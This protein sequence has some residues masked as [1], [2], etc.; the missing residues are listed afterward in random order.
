MCSEKNTMRRRGRKGFTFIEIM[1]V[2]VI[3]GLLAGAVTLKVMGNV[4]SA[5]VSR[6]RSDIATIKSAIESYYLINS[7]F[8]TNDEGLENLDISSR[9]D[10]WGFVYEYNCPGQDNRSFEVVTYG[11]DGRPGGDGPNADIYSWQLG[12]QVAG[13]NR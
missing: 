8:P 10:P 4:D 6:A 5:K 12:D 7:R 11:A 2:V 13:A 9:T 1:V 3:I